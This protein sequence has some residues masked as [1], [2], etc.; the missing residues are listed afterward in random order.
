MVRSKQINASNQHIDIFMNNIE[1]K[2]GYIN[3]EEQFVTEL[4]TLLNRKFILD[5][6]LSANTD[7][8]RDGIRIQK[9]ID[10]LEHTKKQI[11]KLI[12]L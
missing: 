6:I 9:M 12:G 7:E 8:L 1:L 3:A 5:K 4:S 2:H 11:T 10:E